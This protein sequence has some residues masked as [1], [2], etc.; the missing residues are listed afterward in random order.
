MITLLSFLSQVSAFRLG[1]LE[2]GRPDH[3]LLRRCTGK[4]YVSQVPVST[5]RVVE[6]F[7]DS[8]FITINE[9]EI[10]SLF[11]LRLSGF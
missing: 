1:T 10:K 7:V 4:I 3:V 8:Y 11:P 5:S 6:H 9:F 2:P